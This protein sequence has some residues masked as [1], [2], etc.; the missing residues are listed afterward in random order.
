ME[1]MLKQGTILISESNN[2][3][4]IQKLLGAGGQGEVYEIKKGIETYALKW[5][6]KSSATRMQKE[7]LKNLIAKG[8]PDECFLWPIELINMKS[9]DGFGYVMELR[10]PE[11]RSIVDIMKRRV[12]PSFEVLIKASYN[13]TLGYQ[14]LHSLGYSYRDI[15]FGNVFF[16]PKTGEVLI[17]DNDNVSVNG[18]EACAV[19]G[20]PRFMAPEIIRREAMPSRNTD[21]YSLSVLLFYIFMMHHPLE[22]KRE[23]DIHCMDVK[24]MNHIYGIDPLFIYDGDD[25]SNRPVSGYQDNAI[26]YWELYPQKI[27]KL[28]MQ[29]FTRGLHKPTHRVTESKWLHS[30]SELQSQLITCPCCGAENF[31]HEDKVSKNE[32]HQ[33]WNCCEILKMPAI[34]MIE[35]R[36]VLL[37][38]KREIYSQY[39]YGDY[40][41]STKIGEVVRNPKN[42]NILGIKN[43]SC[44][45]WKYTR[46]DGTVLVVEPS[47]AVAVVKGCKI[48]WNGTKGIIQ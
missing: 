7:I 27:K 22:G 8:K 13:L 33:C 10:H 37:E 1:G 18:N 44:E 35:G 34:L 47:R 6:F 14:K 45:N 21:L 5:Y 4:I 36:T 2:R 25:T 28:F 42:P 41:M 17:C 20:T 46:I 26:I 24:A 15:S 38:H 11:Y 31:Y 12:E 40:D 19:Y 43:L 29:A 16:H 23:A 39:V 30:L 32:K 48:E 9:V 3:Y